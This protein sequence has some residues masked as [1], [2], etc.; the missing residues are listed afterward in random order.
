MLRTDLGLNFEDNLQ[1][2]TAGNPGKQTANPAQGVS[3]PTSPSS[4]G[5]SHRAFSAGYHP[6]Y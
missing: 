6:A 4:E 1:Q 5:E 2:A 3:K